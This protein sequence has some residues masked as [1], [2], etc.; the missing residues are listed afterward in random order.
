MTSCTFP[1][2][3]HRRVLGGLAGALAGTWLAWLLAAV[4]IGGMAALTAPA[5]AA[6]TGTGSGPATGADDG[7]AAA[8]H[9]RFDGLHDAIAHNAFGRPLAM[10]S[11]Q[12]SDRL[13]GD[14]IARVDHPFA[15]VVQALQGTPRW[16]DILVLHLNVKQCQ[17]QGDQLHMRLGRK[18]DQ[19]VEDAYALAFAYRVEAS[20]ADYLRVALTAPDGPLGT[21][22]YRIV[23]EASPIDAGHAILRLRYAYGFGT[24]ARL[25]MQGYLSTAGRSKVGF[26]STG[27]DPAAPQYV[28][29]VRGLV[30]RNTMRYYLAIEAVLASPSPDARLAGWFDATE[31]YARQLHEM[32]RADYLAMKRA[33]LRRD[34]ATR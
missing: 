24:M 26:S 31:R 5:W 18:F 13:E 29:G 2:P 20:T 21:R 8:L 33:E 10:S 16:C 7:G 27:G 4:L 34:A 22:D 3:V 6:G 1:R 12:A 30:E 32:D 17:G 23:V 11:T 25:A 15:D 14:I 9:A 28:G 19:P